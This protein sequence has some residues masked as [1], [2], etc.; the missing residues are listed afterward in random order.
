MGRRGK[1]ALGFF[2]M[3]R[4]PPLGHHTPQHVLAD[5]AGGSAWQVVHDFHPF[6]EFLS[7]QTGFLQKGGQCRP[8]RPGVS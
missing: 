3:K 7:R 6:R 5:L 1:P 4:A 2:M 8:V